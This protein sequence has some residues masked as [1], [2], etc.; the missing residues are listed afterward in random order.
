MASGT[1]LNNGFAFWYMR[2]GKGAAKEEAEAKEGQPVAGSPKPQQQPV[3]PQTGQIV[4]GSGN[5]YESSIKA[6]ST[7]RTVE[8]FWGTYDFLTRPNDLPN[9]TDYHFF[10]EGIKPT[11]EDSGNAK[12]GKWIVRLRKGLASRYWE[13]TILALIGGQF[14][15]VPDGEICGAVVSIRYSED[16]LGIWN[17]TSS[18]RDITE[19]IRE[20][21]KKILQ[22]PPHAHM[23]SIA[24]WPCTRTQTQTHIDRQIH[25]SVCV[26]GSLTIS[27]LCL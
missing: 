10:R 17:R 19:R 13:E 16:I 6:I 14:T 25:M 26:C 27:Q 24:T 5:S 11:W 20:A 21:I 23:V 12:G 2:R 7:V 18:D 9:T 3:V 1:A 4:A 15:G 22:L 8:D